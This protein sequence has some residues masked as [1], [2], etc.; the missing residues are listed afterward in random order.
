[1]AENFISTPN[2]SQYTR[3]Y[4]YFL[5]YGNT[6]WGLSLIADPQLIKSIF[7]LYIKN[8]IDFS[9]QLSL[10]TIFSFCAWLVSCLS[11]T[12]VWWLTRWIHWP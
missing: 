9:P 3:W 2:K 11:W 4:F 1:M 6:G 7:I 5:G 8:K 12:H 10:D